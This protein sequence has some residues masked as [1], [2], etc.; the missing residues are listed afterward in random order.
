MASVKTVEE[1]GGRVGVSAH[2][3]NIPEEL[4]FL[5]KSMTFLKQRLQ[6]T[7]T[8]PLNSL[9]C[10]ENKQTKEIKEKKKLSCDTD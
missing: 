2:I 7:N 3:L 10:V 9:S 8:A 5:V 4:C 1:G 6:K